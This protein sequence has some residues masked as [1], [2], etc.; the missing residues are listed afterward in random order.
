MHE[1]TARMHQDPTYPHLHP[2]PSPSCHQTPQ[3]KQLQCASSANLTSIDPC[4]TK[5]N[6]CLL[7]LPN[8]V[9]V[10]FPISRPSCES[11]HQ[12]TRMREQGAQKL[13]QSHKETE[14]QKSTQRGARKCRQDASRHHRHPFTPLPS[15]RFKLTPTAST[16][17]VPTPT[18]RPVQ[19][20]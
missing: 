7:T 9:H 1:R 13:G 17:V 6:S 19:S 11:T 15:S 2:I 4:R 20:D 16:A 10:H 3:H 18:R 12:D 14:M 8:Q 5:Q